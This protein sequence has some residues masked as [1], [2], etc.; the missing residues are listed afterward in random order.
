MLRSILVLLVAA[1][2]F[3]GCAVRSAAPEAERWSGSLR[4][5]E[6]PGPEVRT[7]L[8]APTS[9]GVVAGAGETADLTVGAFFAR[10]ERDSGDLDQL[11]L[12]LEFRGADAPLLL[13][14]SR[15]LL[16]EVDGELFV[17][18]PGQSSNSFRVDLDGVSPRATVAI[19]IAPE[20]LDR[21]AAA[22][23]VRGRLGL[24]TTF[25]MPPSC[26]ARFR[27]L[28]EAL[29]E[30]AAAGALRGSRLRRVTETD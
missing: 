8:L 17:G 21:L 9:V 19:P 10:Y 18:D 6:G 13:E 28:L 2:L 26:R 20:L 25:T 24:W 23:V 29:P 16:L 27:A 12:M 22:E 30:D 4:W 15:Q 7:L 5:I 3:S 11:A 14:R 1:P